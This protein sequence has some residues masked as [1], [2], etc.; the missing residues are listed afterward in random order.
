MPKLDAVV[1]RVGALRQA[2]GPDFGIGVDFM[3]PDRPMPSNWRKNST[4]FI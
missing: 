3:A 4:P 2:M 1:E